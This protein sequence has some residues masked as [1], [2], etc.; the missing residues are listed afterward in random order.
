LCV[1]ATSKGPPSVWKVTE[2]T[3]PCWHDGSNLYKF[4]YVGD[5]GAFHLV[6]ILSQG[7]SIKDL[8]LNN[9]ITEDARLIADGKTVGVVKMEYPN[10][11]EWL[12]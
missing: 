3:L 11:A 1:F 12:S 7:P 8:E 4:Y 6:T 2:Q 10:W 5:D 9:G